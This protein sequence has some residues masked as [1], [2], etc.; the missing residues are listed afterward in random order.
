V[1]VG[2]AG[3]E[4]Q[5]VNVAP[6]TQGTDAVNLNQ[7]QQS[8]SNTLNQANAY[9]NQKFDDARRDA[10]GGTAS[11]IAIASLPQAVLPGHGMVAVGGGTYGGQSALAI[12]VSQL[13]DNGVWAYKFTGTTSTRGQFGVGVGAGMH[14]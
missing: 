8:S 10:Y 4:R 13:S 7:L 14:W 1:S 3:Q 6:G 9:T 2:A 11:A 12:G 5:I